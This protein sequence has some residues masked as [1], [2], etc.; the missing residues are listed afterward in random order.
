M[1]IFIHSG[2]HWD[3]EWYQSFQGFRFRLAGVT[4]GIIETLE[5]QD[6]YGIFHFDGQTIVLEDYLEIEP[7]K[8][9]RL[10]NLIR[11]GKIVIGPWYCMP[12]EFLCSG[13]SLIKNLRRGHRIAREEFG[14]EPSKNGYICDIFGHIAQMP[15]IFA[16]MNIRH[17]VL[18]RGTN[19]HTTPTHFRW[20][21]PDGTQVTAFKLDDRDGYSDFTAFAGSCP[22]TLPEA[23]FDAGVKAYI[24]R[25]TERSNIPVLFLLDALDH[26]GIRPETARYADAIRRLYPEA[27]V[28]H[29]NIKAMNDAQDEYFATLPVKAGE[30]NETAKVNAGYLHL[31]TNTL[32]SRY[33]LK[34]A[35]DLLQTKLEK[36]VSPLYAFGLTGA[37]QG[38]LTLADKY[39][40]QNHPHDSI[41]GCSIDVV[42]RDMMYRFR[43][44]DM[45]ADELLKPFAASLAGEFP[46]LTPKAEGAGKLLR[47]FNPLPYAAKRALEAEITFE[48]SWPKYAEPFGYENINRFHIADADGVVLPYGISDIRTFGGHDVYTVVF[49]AELGAA[50]VTEFAVLPTPMPSRYPA[51][52]LTSAL[53]ASGDK[54]ALKV[55]DNGTVDLTDLVTGEVYKNLLTLIDDGE[56]GDGWF[57]CSPAIDKRVTNTTAFAEVTENTC[58]RVTFKITQT[59]RLPEGIDRA[60]HGTRRS[61]VYK[62]FTVT[63]YVTLAKASRFLEVR[64]VIDNNVGDHRLRLRFPTGC[65]GDTY[66]VSQ[67]FCFTERKTGAA[68]GTDDWKE[69]GVIEKQTSGIAGKTDAKNNRRGFAFISAYGLHECGVSANGDIDVT[70]FRAFS[71]TVGTEGEPDGQLNETLE[72]RCVVEPLDGSETYASLQREQD[73]LQTGVRCATASGKPRKYRPLFAAGYPLIYSTAGLVETGSEIRL[74]NCSASDA[75]EKLLL[76]DGTTSAALT[77]LEGNV[78]QNLIVEDGSCTLRLGKWKIATVVYK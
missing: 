38:F 76:P 65:A 17:T 37:S 45:I 28:F 27:G 30:L 34:K 20:E 69:F 48:S 4:D 55:N 67:P 22:V 12:D 78:L 15:Q 52:L 46:P 77:D 54:L 42:H 6:D 26:I 62:D 19:Q 63:H 23:E 47:V 18:G 10:T 59:L 40:L 75:E 31:I 66:F 21:A 49:E 3:R 24:D 32:S 57:H 60:H 11:S 51:R 68:P 8:R 43:Q 9:E 7:R 39:L 72:F 56:I 36:W 29:T 13:E 73:F 61:D 25:Q 33:P 44:A 14:T 74:W 2:T 70:L 35:N 50:C 1:K 64:T 58:A 71:K 16:A 53:S 5:K 41:C